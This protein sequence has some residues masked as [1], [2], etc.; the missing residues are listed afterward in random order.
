MRIAQIAPLT[1]A[2][3]P[4]LYG[5][6]E[7]VIYWLTEELVGLGHELTLFASGDSCTSGELVSIWPQALRLDGGIRDPNALHMAMLEQVRQRAPEFDVI[8]SHLDY[9]PFPGFMMQATPFITT[10]HGRLD[11]PERQVVL[12]AFSSV[13][14]VSISD[15]QRRPVPQARWIR[16]VYHGI[17]EQLLRPTSVAP[18][19]LAFL[20]R[21]S[22]E[23]GIESAIRIARSCGLPLK[24]A[25]K[26]DKADQAYFDE[27]IRPLLSPPSV[28]YIGEI[29]DSE[30]SA[31]LS[32]AVALLNLI[33]YPEP[34]GLVATEAMAC[35]TPSI[36]FDRGAIPEVVEHGRT[37]FIVRSEAEAINAICRVD[38]LS[39]AEIRQRFEQRFTAR[40]MAND[41][42]EVYRSLIGIPERYSVRSLRAAV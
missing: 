41:Y 34:F 38:R 39:Q 32:G 19:Y 16:T 42:L 13:P 22:P 12:D 30:K 5:G 37:G 10:W 3:P 17:P 36:A 6:I 28:E 18:T 35:G 29:S 27:R 26:I 8:H 23:K 1:E 40:R 24:V 21:I 33:D 31:F 2:V 7:R 11:L 25:A 20:G 9:F 14:V 15:A 4:R